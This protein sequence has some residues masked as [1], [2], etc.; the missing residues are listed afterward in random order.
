MA[1]TGAVCMHMRVCVSGSSGAGKSCLI[2]RMVSNIFVH[3]TPTTIGIDYKT[4]PVETSHGLA[5]AIQFR[6]LAGQER[7]RSVCAMSY[8][9]IDA[10]LVVFDLA[11][12]APGLDSDVP[13]WIDQAAKFAGDAVPVLLVANKVDDT[14][15]LADRDRG[16]LLHG[17]GEVVEAR[18][19]SGSIYYVS[20]KTGVGID[21]VVQ[22][23]CHILESAERYIEAASAVVVGSAAARVRAASG[24]ISGDAYSGADIPTPNPSDALLNVVVDADGMARIVKAPQFV[25]LVGGNPAQEPGSSQ[26]V[27]LSVSRLQSAESRRASGSG[28]C[29]C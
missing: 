2:T 29:A 7:F 20:A 26:V 27:E 28:G 23:L 11:R 22:A 17:V 12:G 8:R 1:D 15:E 9:N 14:S 4:M 10:V 13:Y 19:Y 18:A 25:K 21:A 5:A 16:L 3:N 6:D 24:D